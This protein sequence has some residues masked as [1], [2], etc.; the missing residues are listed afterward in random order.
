LPAFSCEEVGVRL[1]STHDYVQGRAMHPRLAVVSAIAVVLTAALVPGSGLGSP[2][3]GVRDAR[4]I[5]AGLEGAIHGQ[6]GAGRISLASGGS[7]HP[8]M[9]FSVAL[10]ADGTTALVSAYGVAKEKGAAYIYQASG[11]DSWASSS[12]PTATLTPQK[13]SPDHGFG[14]SVA[15]SG[16][17]TTAFIGAPFASPTGAVEVFHVSDEGAWTSTSTPTATLTASADDLTGVSVAASSDGT[18]VVA[19]VPFHDGDTRAAN[20]FHVA[21][22]DAWASTSTPTAVLTYSGESHANLVIG[23]AVAI[24]GDGTTVLLGDSESRHFA[25]SAYLFHVASEAAWASTSAPTA[26]LTNANRV[27]N[28]LYGASLALSGDGTTAFLGAPFH[29]GHTG[30]VDVFHAAD[31][32]A[33]ASSSTPTAILTK[34]AGAK[35]DSFGDRVAVSSDGTTAVITAPGV[36]HDTG[37]AYVFHVADAGAWTSSSAPTATLTNSAGARNDVLGVGLGMSTDGA[38]VLLGAPWVNWQTGAADVF[39]VADPTS[40][41]TSSAP[42]A[43]LTNSALPKPACVVPP[44]KGLTVADAKLFLPY[45]NCRLGKVSRVHAKSKKL[46]KRIVS[47]NRAPGRHLRPGAKINVRVGK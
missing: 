42:A 11:A 40:W 31:A 37:A 4:V 22:E 19:A 12:T 36:H 18:T 39:H 47:Q 32:D 27:A 45:E 38:T 16:D 28:D 35:N 29:R 10:S 33:W 5:P 46:R 3:A 14:I 30:E 2:G 41:L 15:L 1:F 23:P 9:G 6:L 13:G 25:G 26:I 44:L 20:V 24:S 43:T 17:G 8:Q 21:S 7:D 34:T